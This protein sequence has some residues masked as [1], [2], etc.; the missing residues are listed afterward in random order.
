MLDSIGLYGYD[1]GPGDP[2]I[3][4]IRFTQGG[5]AGDYDAT[6]YTP[7]TLSIVEAPLDQDG[8]SRPVW[9]ILVKYV[10]PGKGMVTLEIATVWE[11]Q[12]WDPW[13]GQGGW[14]SKRGYITTS[15][16]CIITSGMM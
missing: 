1:L 13:G 8:K 4:S 10:M 14:I 15:P 5:K 9:A 12:R 16:N 2:G 7:C 11:H 3:S 6:P